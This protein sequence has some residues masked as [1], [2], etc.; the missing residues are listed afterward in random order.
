MKQEAAVGRRDTEVL[1]WEAA[2]CSEWTGQEDP[3]ILPNMHSA[4]CQ[5]EAKEGR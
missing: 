1:R 5:C 3:L 4:V 2:G